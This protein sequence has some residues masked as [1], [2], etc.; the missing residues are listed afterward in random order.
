MFRGRRNRGNS[1]LVAGSWPT[2]TRPICDPKFRGYCYRWQRKDSDATI[3]M[4]QKVGMWCDRVKSRD[5]ADLL[6]TTIT[7]NVKVQC[8]HYVFLYRVIETHHTPIIYLHTQVKFR[9]VGEIHSFV[10]KY[11]LQCII[12]EG[13]SNELITLIIYVRHTPYMDNILHGNSCSN[14]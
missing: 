12:I 14:V 7:H 10:L 3:F 4:K 9:S 13:T 8:P 5:K 11:I 1:G 2:I 6:L